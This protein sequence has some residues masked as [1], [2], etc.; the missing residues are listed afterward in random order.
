LGVKSSIR[1]A[2]RGRDREPDPEDDDPQAPTANPA[3]TA[4]IDK[5][6]KRRIGAP[7]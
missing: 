1:V 4:T 6:A 7:A 2:F 3:A 5:T